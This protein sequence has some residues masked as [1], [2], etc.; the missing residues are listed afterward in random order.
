MQKN[1]TERKSTDA[2]MD[3]K[4]RKKGVSRLLNFGFTFQ[5]NNLLVKYVKNFLSEESQ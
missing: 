5:P 3:F 1:K 4:L 2:F